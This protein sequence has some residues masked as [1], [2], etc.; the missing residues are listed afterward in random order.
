M[1]GQDVKKQIASLLVAFILCSSLTLPAWA[2]RTEISESSITW[3]TLGEGESVRSYSREMGWVLV[4]TGNDIKIG[5]GVFREE[6]RIIDLKTQAEVREYNFFSSFEEDLAVVGL[7]QADVEKYGFID[8]AGNAVIPLEYTQANGFSEGMAAVGIGAWESAI[9]G[10]IDKTGKTIIQP[11]YDEAGDFF[12]VLYFGSILPLQGVDIVLK[13]A[14]ILQKNTAIHFTLIGP[15]KEGDGK[16]ESDTIT[17]IPWLSQEQLA[18]AIAQADLCLAGHFNKDINKAKRTIPGKAYIYRAMEKP[19]IL[20]D[21][22]ATREL[23]S[24]DM[25]GIYFV[26]MGNPQALAKKILKIKE[27]Y[28]IKTSNITNDKSRDFVE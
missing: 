12:E 4:Y 11:E 19:M 7:C 23:Y 27:E 14:Q 20:G 24:E 13:S 10:Y 18:E 22:S 8:K 6:L 3:F 2:T 17:Y 15:I 26:E 5:D 21:N 9:Y 1:E 16:V 25:D 28:F